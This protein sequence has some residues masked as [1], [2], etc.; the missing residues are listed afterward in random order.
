MVGLLRIL[1]YGN[2][3][4]LRLIACRLIRETAL[5][6]RTAWETLTSRYNRLAVDV[7]ECYA[8]GQATEEE[9]AASNED[10]WQVLQQ[11]RK[12]RAS[13]PVEQIALAVYEVG[14][15]K[16]HQSGLWN[17]LWQTS[18]AVLWN[19]M[20]VKFGNS[21]RFCSNRSA[22]LH[23]AATKSALAQQANIIREMIPAEEVRGCW[24]RYIAKEDK[25]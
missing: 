16:F 13:E 4:S 25:R 17:V 8:N 23:D 18:R 24:E 12:D 14:I 6:G 5:H 3:E 22:Y 15:P 9:L 20:K 11:L 10:A 1:R 21:S 19:S 7:A 2:S